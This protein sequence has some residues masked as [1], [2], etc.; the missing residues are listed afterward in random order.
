MSLNDTFLSGTFAQDPTTAF[1]DNVTQVTSVTEGDACLVRGKLRW[2]SWEK[3]G[4]KQGTLI[5]HTWS[6]QMLTPQEASI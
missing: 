3:E 6:V 5:V 4:Q 2:K 1:Q